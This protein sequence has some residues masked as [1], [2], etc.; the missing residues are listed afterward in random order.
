MKKTKRTEVVIE[1]EQVFV[2]RKL[3]NRVPQCCPQ[4]RD[5]AQ[6]VSVDQASSIVRLTARAIYQQ[7]ESQR[8]HYAETPDG[9]LLICLSSLL[10]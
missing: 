4:C 1:R 7:V 6:M 3:D 10:Q 5:Q 2:I 8:V 9:K